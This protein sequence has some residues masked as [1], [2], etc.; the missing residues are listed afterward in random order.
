MSSPAVLNLITP[1]G[2][3]NFSNTDIE[4]IGPED[5]VSDF[6]PQQ[7]KSLLP[8][9]YRHC[10]RWRPDSGFRSNRGKIG[11][12]TT[13]DSHSPSPRWRPQETETMAVRLHRRPEIGGPTGNGSGN[14]QTAR[15]AKTALQPLRCIAASPRMRCRVG[16]VT[17]PAGDCSACARTRRRYCG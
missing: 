10:C 2:T 5:T 6:P 13:I 3:D 8:E 16:R 9:L 15:Q 4:G 1:R 12:N 14:A 7:K 11:K 17:R